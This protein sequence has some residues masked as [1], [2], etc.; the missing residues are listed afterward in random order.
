M[1][2]ETAPKDSAAQGDNFTLGGEIIPDGRGGDCGDVR[3]SAEG[4]S[5]RVVLPD[6]HRVCKAR[7]SSETG[8]AP[9]FLSGSHRSCVVP[10]KNLFRD[11]R[12]AESRG[13]RA[14]GFVE[15]N[16]NFSK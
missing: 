5:C 9:L 4:A 12:A 7:A 2:L 16:A 6:S 10:F 15:C 14:R 13:G 3:A 11:G 1:D 8:A